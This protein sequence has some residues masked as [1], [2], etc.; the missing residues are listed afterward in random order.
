MLRCKGSPNVPATPSL[1]HPFKSNLTSR[2]TSILLFLYQLVDTV[3]CRPFHI[4]FL[5]L[6]CSLLTCLTNLSPFVFL[7]SIRYSVTHRNY[8]FLLSPDV[9]TW[10]AHLNKALLLCLPSEHNWIQ[11][12]GRR[13]TSGSYSTTTC[14]RSKV[15]MQTYLIT[16]ACSW[17]EIERGRVEWIRCR[18]KREAKSNAVQIG[19]F[20][21]N[22]VGK[23]AGLRWKR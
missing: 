5:N 23:R 9:F 15:Y 4:F 14:P 22:P 3:Y 7:Q 10:N 11:Q 1:S 21:Q 12:C 20:E 6:I 13:K 8:Y 17:H 18:R 16:V 19:K 2:T